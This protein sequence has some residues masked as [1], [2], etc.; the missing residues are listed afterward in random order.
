MSFSL[1]PPE[2]DPTLEAPLFTEEDVA[3]HEQQLIKVL[4]F[5]WKKMTKAQKQSAKTFLSSFNAYYLVIQNYNQN[6]QFHY[7][8]ELTDIVFDK[9]ED[10]NSG[11]MPQILQ[12]MTIFSRHCIHKLIAFT[13]IDS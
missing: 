5:E 11:W 8:K 10:D 2:V 4:R 9:I 1:D 6:S 13:D 12:L 3:N 7:P